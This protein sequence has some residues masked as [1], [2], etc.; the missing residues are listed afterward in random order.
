MSENTLVIKNIASIF[1][2]GATDRIM[3]KTLFVKILGYRELKNEELEVLQQEM[4]FGGELIPLKDS[5]VLYS[6]FRN[7][8]LTIKS[9]Y[10]KDNL[11]KFAKESFDVI[12]LLK[13]SLKSAFPIEGFKVE[14]QNLF[15]AFVFDEDMDIEKLNELRKVYRDHREVLIETQLAPE[16]IGLEIFIQYFLNEHSDWKEWFEKCG[17]MLRNIKSDSFDKRR[18][19]LAKALIGERCYYQI[20]GELFGKDKDEVKDYLINSPINWINSLGELI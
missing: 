9:K 2:E 13:R 8:L 6:D 10:G 1:V 3:Y 14:I 17:E 18:F 12:I 20:F 16:K 7:S 5:I 15:I 11:L 19:L 4:K